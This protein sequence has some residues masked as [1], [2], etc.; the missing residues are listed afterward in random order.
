MSEI[1]LT[2]SCPKCSHKG[3]AKNISYGNKLVCSKCKRKFVFKKSLKIKF[4][5][6]CPH[7]DH[8]G[9]SKQV[10]IGKT[11]TCSKCSGR[12]L[13]T[14]DGI[15][16]LANNKKRRKK[17]KDSTNYSKYNSYEKENTSY[18]DISDEKRMAKILGL[19]GK[20]T[21]DDIHKAYRNKIKEYHPDKIATMADELKELALKRTQEINEAY[22]HF[23][24]KYS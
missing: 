15:K 6:S 4:T 20:V 10:I 7:C 22:K 17:T 16:P 2:F 1:K 13:L 14:K 18:G 9:T 23:K 3:T 24:D 19:S 12:M 8:Y 21:K 5:L 11:A